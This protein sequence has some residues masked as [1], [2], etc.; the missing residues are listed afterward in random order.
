MSV[1]YMLAFY[2]YV[3][4]ELPQRTTRRGAAAALSGARTAAHVEAR[5]GGGPWRGARRSKA[6]RRPSA[7]GATPLNVTSVL[8]SLLHRRAWRRRGEGSYVSLSLSSTLSPLS[9]SLISLSLAGDPWMPDP[10]GGGAPARRSS[11]SGASGATAGGGCGSGERSCGSGERSHG[12]GGGAADLGR[13]RWRGWA[14][15]RADMG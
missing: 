4:I 3:N 9:T 8:L 11:S 7:S 13:R 6:R 14:R 12:S 2:H 10:V 1:T 15:C 5:R